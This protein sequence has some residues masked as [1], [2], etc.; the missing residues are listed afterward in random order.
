[1]ESIHKQACVLIQWKQRRGT[2]YILEHDIIVSCAHV[3]PSPGESVFVSFFDDRRIDAVVEQVDTKNDIAILKP[4]VPLAGLP[5]LRLSRT[6]YKSETPFASYGFP[7]STGESG[8]TLS[9]KILD[10][11]GQDL[12]KISS[13]VLSSPSLT[14]NAQLQGLSGAPVFSQG[15]LI[16]HLKQIVPDQQS[17]PQFGI[18]YACP[19]SAIL[20]L[21]DNRCAMP[22]I[23]ECSTEC[24]FDLYSRNVEKYY[25]LREIDK[26]VELHIKNQSVWVFG[27]S[28]IGKTCLLQRAISRGDGEFRYITLS[29][30]V[31][32]NAR[33]CLLH[34]CEDIAEIVGIRD[35][36]EVSLRR[37]LE[38]TRAAIC[39]SSRSLWIYIDEIP[40]SEPKQL[41]LFTDGITGL[42]G[43]S[44]INSNCIRILISSIFGPK[45]YISTAQQ[46][47][48][49]RMKFI[50]MPAWKP[51]EIESLIE[52]LNCSLPG[53][54]S[55][56]ELNMLAQ[57]PISSPRFVKQLFRN[58]M[59]QI[60]SPIEI[61]LQQTT[62]ELKEA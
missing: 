45:D 33:S 31:G 60:S 32:G 1:M 51:G 43:S 18:V 55:E 35:R 48:S 13:I 23:A 7:L 52:L 30:S 37:A 14:S 12:N 44:A 9:G 34:L 53:L 2:G 36:P 5:F 61:L 6:D 40:I 25:L 20:R 42:I 39:Q 24:L 8:V 56:I 46:R 57:Y 3:V 62:D 29:A 58:K 49:E 50:N 27:A 19:S 4:R 41:K 17:C 16:G 22:S 11:G 10:P 54:F 28:G 38:K 21:L 15:M 26:Q 47:I 59:A